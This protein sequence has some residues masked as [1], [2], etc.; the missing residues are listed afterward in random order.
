MTNEAIQNRE[1]IEAIKAQLS[2]GFITYEQAK[3]QAEP[4]IA[5]INAKA[6]EIA[7]KYNQRARLV[8][9]NEIMR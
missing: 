7:K 8:S 3:T 4:I 6:K 2:R 9:F 5:S 1:R